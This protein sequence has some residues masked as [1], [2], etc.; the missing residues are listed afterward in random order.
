MAPRPGPE[1]GPV[2]DVARAGQQADGGQRRR[3]AEGRPAAR[4]RRRPIRTSRRSTAV[5]GASCSRPGPVVGPAGWRPRSCRAR[6][7]L[8]PALRPGGPPPRGRRRPSTAVR[9]IRPTSSG[10]WAATRTVRPF[11]PRVE[12]LAEEGLGRQVEMG[13]RLVEQDERCVAQRGPGD[14]H[15]L[16]LAGTE[17]EPPL[18]DPRRQPGGERSDQPRPGRSPRAR[19]RAVPGPRRGRRAGGCRRA[20]RRRG[21][22]A[23]VP[24]R[25]GVA[26]R[27]GRRRP[28]RRRRSTPSRPRGLT[29]PRSTARTV[30]LPTPDG[31]TSATCSPSSIVRSNRSS[32]GRDRPENVTSMPSR[33]TGN[34]RPGTGVRR[35]GRAGVPVAV[36]GVVPMAVAGPTA[37]V[38]PG[39]AG[40]AGRPGR[41]VEEVEDALGGCPALG[42]GVELG[43]GPPERQEDLRGDQEDGE[44]G[45]ERD[46]AAEQ[47]EAEDHGDEPGADAGEELHRQ[48]GEEGDPQRRHRRLAEALGRRGH[49]AAALGGAAERPEGRQTADE[50]EEAG[51]QRREAPPLPSRLRRGPPAEEDH[52]HRHERDDPEQDEQRDPVRPGHPGE[53]ADRGEA[54]QDRLRQVP[55]EVDVERRGAPRRGQGQLAGPFAGQPHRSEIERVAEELAPEDGRDGRAAALGGRLAGPGGRGPDD[56]RHDEPDEQWRDRR[57][58]IRRGAPTAR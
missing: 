25:R 23:A 24:R 51:G 39:D 26:T 27:P 54:G 53:D 34:G 21:A 3:D 4:R 44:R 20:S 2:D 1:R 48:C 19:G 46:R 11:E 43:A 5:V 22:V 35:R 33:R 56:E 28:G 40:A 42:A 13:D 45:V 29:K 38:R 41:L 49:L 58:A 55:A 15:S 14:G 9:S 32:V 17:R 47:P 8:M 16:S 52:R 50:L 6:V 18:T 57:R 30:D 37:A 31:P 36:V 7:A 12:R 10:R